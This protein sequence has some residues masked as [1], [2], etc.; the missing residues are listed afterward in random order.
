MKNLFNAQPNWLRQVKKNGAMLV[1]ATGVA[2][3]GIVL[4]SFDESEVADKKKKWKL[5]W[6]DEFNKNGRP[7]STKW[8]Y[9]TGFAR[10]HEAQWYQPENAWCEGGNLI[11]EA[12]K[13]EKPNPLYVSGSNDWRK[14][15]EKIEYTSSSLRTLKSQTWQYGRF[16]LRAKIDT[17]PGMWPAW[18]TLGINGE[19]PSNG[20][21]DIMEYYRGKLL[22]NIAV[23]TNQRYKAEWYSETRK[24]S[25]MGAGW[26][27]NFHI[28]RM[29]WDENEIALYVDDKLLIKVPQSKLNNKNASGI[30][31]FKQPHYMILNLALGGD[32]GGDPSLTSYPRRYVIDY[33]R[34]YQEK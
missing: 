33:V 25:E 18:W 6:S 32:N 19:W 1:L 2:A 17:A 29:D 15:R 13:E 27:D 28:W 30:V 3:A 7:D 21:I 23:G 10:N 20:E 16:E 24:V 14:S 26:S 34:V 11:I 8:D 12:R 5:V 22:A 4:A 31:P 9:E